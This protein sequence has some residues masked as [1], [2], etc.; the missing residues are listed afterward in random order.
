VAEPVFNTWVRGRPSPGAGLSALH[1]TRQ[2]SQDPLTASCPLAQP[3]TP[4]E[5]LHGQSI[6][7]VLRTKPLTAPA[8]GSDRRLSGEAHQ[9]GSHSH[10]SDHEPQGSLPGLQGRRAGPR[11]GMRVRRKR[12]HLCARDLQPVRRQRA[13]PSCAVTQPP[14]LTHRHHRPWRGRS[15]RTR[16]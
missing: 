1:G 10:R 6:L 9:V 15:P 2:G 8:P 14:D 3:L 11:A 16:A 12:A 4:I 5:P 13:C 7:E